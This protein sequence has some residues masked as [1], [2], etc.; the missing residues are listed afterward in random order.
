MDVYR[1]RSMENV[2]P[3]FLPLLKADLI[4]DVAE[5]PPLQISTSSKV[6]GRLG[7]GLGFRNRRRRFRSAS[8]REGQRKCK[9]IY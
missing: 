6:R 3:V 5:A 2:S 9:D 4:I 8:G 7:P 1:D